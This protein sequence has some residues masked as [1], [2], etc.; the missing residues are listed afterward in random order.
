MALQFC[1][2]FQRLKR[3]FYLLFFPL[4]FASKCAWTFKVCK[5]CRVPSLSLVSLYRAGSN[6]QS[7]EKVPKTRTPLHSRRGHWSSRLEFI[8]DIK[9][10]SVL[11]QHTND[12][13]RA[14]HILQC[15][16]L[17]FGGKAQ[18]PAVC[19]G[20]IHSSTNA[21]CY[22]CGSCF[23]AALLCLMKHTCKPLLHLET[24]KNPV[25]CSSTCKPSSQCIWCSNKKIKATGYVLVIF[26]NALF[27]ANSSL[28][29][30][31]KGKRFEDMERS[32][33]T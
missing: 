1:T 32:Q 10:V 4:S 30:T 3:N 12:A 16:A 7:H 29:S 5:C 15:R 24:V 27:F 17:V 6:L 25:G 13:L 26:F 9:P 28:L 8:S 33:R 21:Q 11:S 31:E 19:D 14:L 2:V 18:R 23:V 22:W 20:R